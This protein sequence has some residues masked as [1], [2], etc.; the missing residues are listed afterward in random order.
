[1]HDLLHRLLEPKPKAQVE[2]QQSNDNNNDD[3]DND[4]DDKLKKPAR[5]DE[6]TPLLAPH[7]ENANVLLGRS[8]SQLPELGLFSLC[9][10]RYDCYFKHVFW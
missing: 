3:N 4:D 2:Q 8:D 5:A 1:M 9:L 6:K 10:F 7:V